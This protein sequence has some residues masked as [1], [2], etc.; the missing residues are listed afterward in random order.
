MLMFKF[1]LNFL[2]LMFLKIKVLKSIFSL[3]TNNT[4]HL[5]KSSVFLS[6]RNFTVLSQ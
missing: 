4:V 6:H 5:Y 3:C 1:K 2:I